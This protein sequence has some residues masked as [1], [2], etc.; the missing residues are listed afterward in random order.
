MPKRHTQIAAEILTLTSDRE[1]DMI[2]PME[3]KIRYIGKVI[4]D[5][6]KSFTEHLICPDSGVR[7][8]TEREIQALRKET[9]EF[10]ASLKPVEEHHEDPNRTANP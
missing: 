10:F 2:L 1:W 7:Y 8:F 4:E 3:D 6:V 5:H 9:D